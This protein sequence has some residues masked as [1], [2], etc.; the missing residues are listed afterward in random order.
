MRSDG[1]SPGSA[2]ET[3]LIAGLPAKEKHGRSRAACRHTDTGHRIMA[4]YVAEM[5]ERRECQ[6]LS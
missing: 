1:G 3:E 5:D 6:I 2:M 4:F